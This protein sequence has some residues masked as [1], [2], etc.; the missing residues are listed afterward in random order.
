MV[1]TADS[2]GVLLVDDHAIFRAGVRALLGTVRGITVVGEANDGIEALSMIEK[3]RPDVVVMDL[4][5][6]GGDGAT[7]TAKIA[8]MSPRPKVL[9]LTMYSEEDRL[10]TLLTAGASGFLSKDADGGDLITAIKAVA[11][12]D[13]YVRPKAAGILA[14]RI[15]PV[16]H[17]SPA[18]EARAKLLK[19]SD[20][21]R[22]VLRHVAEGYNGPEIGSRIGISSKTVETYKQRISEKIGLGHR[23][24]YVRFALTAGLMHGGA[25][26]N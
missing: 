3:C 18:D 5:M 15:R 1:M 20:R 11:A 6:P 22:E 25:P 4:D 10:I 9:I 7:A 2:I 14:A 17:G 13:M 8:T 26:E 24:E 12:G 19:L 21:E 16:H 23:A